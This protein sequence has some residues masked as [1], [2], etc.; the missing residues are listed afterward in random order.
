MSNLQRI[1]RRKQLIFIILLIY[2][3]L[4][5]ESGSLQRERQ[6]IQFEFSLQLLPDYVVERWFWYIHYIL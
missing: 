6:Y 5:L 3:Y 1:K 2:Q 4:E